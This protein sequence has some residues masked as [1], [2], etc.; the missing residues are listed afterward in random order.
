M[1]LYHAP[2]S[3]FVRMVTVTLHETGQAED[4]ELVSA[5]GSPLDPGSAPIAHNPL[6]K[7]P[8]LERD[9]GPAIFDSRVICRFLNNR[10]GAG[11]YPPMPRGIETEVLEAAAHGIAESALQIV[12]EKRLRPAEKQ[13]PEYIEGQWDKITR[14]VQMIPRRWPSHL[15]G[16]IDGGQ[17]ALGCALGYLD[18]RHSDRDWRSLSPSLAD[19]FAKFAERPSMQATHPR[20]PS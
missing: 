7:L 14:A 17:I 4:V 3:P 5:Y 6:G 9:D 11:L 8:T 1:R 15:A 12:Y 19:W 2:S 16:P 20:D 18:F 13:M 10:A